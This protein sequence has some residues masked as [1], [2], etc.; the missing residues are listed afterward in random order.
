M[1]MPNF[2]GKTATAMSELHRRLLRDL[3]DRRMSKAGDFNTEARAVRA[4]VDALLP[5]LGPGLFHDLVR[6]STPNHLFHHR[7]SARVAR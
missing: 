4:W 6:G 7:L 3:P 1:P 2:S 5:Q